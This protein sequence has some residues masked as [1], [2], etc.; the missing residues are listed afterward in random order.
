M[1]E[2][3]NLSSTTE[4]PHAPSKL[5]N[6]RKLTH[7]NQSSEWREAQKIALS[8]RKLLL[9]TPHSSATQNVQNS[10]I[11]AG[12]SWDINSNGI[13][14]FCDQPLIEVGRS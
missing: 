12:S 13:R 7:I 5:H 10:L 8:A 9:K 4:Q 11:P 1:H 14:E 6:Q 2:E 3:R